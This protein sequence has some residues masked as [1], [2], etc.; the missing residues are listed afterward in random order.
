M[1][2]KSVVSVLKN[3]KNHEKKRK[4][5]ISMMNMEIDFYKTRNFF[6]VIHQIPILKLKIGKFYVN[7]F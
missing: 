5:K 4:E 6:S 3:L 2:Y 1:F 7:L